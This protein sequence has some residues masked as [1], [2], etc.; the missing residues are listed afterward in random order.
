MKQFQV[1]R[2]AERRL[3]DLKKAYEK[4][5]KVFLEGDS[6]QDGAARAPRHVVRVGTFMWSVGEPLA[7]ISGAYKGGVP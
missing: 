3:E 1:E 6:D 7:F 4:I 2:S 5:Y